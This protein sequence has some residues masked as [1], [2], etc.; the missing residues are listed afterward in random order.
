MQHFSGV[1]DRRSGVG[2]ATMVATF[3][4]AW[5][6]ASRSGWRGGMGTKQQ[7]SMSG[8]HLPQDHVHPATHSPNHQLTTTK[9]PQ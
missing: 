3:P 7:A 1:A 8:G 6:H 9:P 5:T 2:V 4:I